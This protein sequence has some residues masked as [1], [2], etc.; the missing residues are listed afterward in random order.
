MLLLL[1]VTMS[2]R[3]SGLYYYLLSTVKRQNM[4]K[5]TVFTITCHHEYILSNY[6]LQRDVNLKICSFYVY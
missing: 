3:R 1:V 4:A 6:N 2:W 5:Q